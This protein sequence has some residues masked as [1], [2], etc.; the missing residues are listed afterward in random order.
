MM[1][2]KRNM[3]QLKKEVGGSRKKEKLVRTLNGPFP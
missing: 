3:I 1:C 2:V